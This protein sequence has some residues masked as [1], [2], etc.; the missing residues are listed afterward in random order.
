MQEVPGRKILALIPARGGSKGIPGKNIRPLAGRPLIC[1]SI[2][3]ALQTPCLDRVVVTTDDPEISA[4]ARQAGAETPFLRP[5]ELAGD[6][7]TDL[8]VYCHALEWL[9]ENQAYRPEVVV[10]LRPTAPLRTVADIEGAVELLL[11]TGADWIRTVCRV[12]HHPYWMY[13]LEG[14]RMAPLL[15]GLDIGKYPRRQQL[16]P[17]Y[18]LN[19]AVEVAWSRTLLEKQLFYSGDVRGY[20]MPRR[21]SVDIDTMAD[22]LAAEALLTGRV[23]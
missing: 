16:P 11:R 19:G 23:A 21:R 20:V 9:A 4:I 14:D 2:D 8:P 1:W 10:W 15:P 17:V 3:T 18:R 13:R 12:R 6:D 22:F 5:A 7:T